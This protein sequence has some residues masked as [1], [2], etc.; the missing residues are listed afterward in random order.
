MRLTRKALSKFSCLNCFRTLFA[1]RVKEEY[2]EEEHEEAF[3]KDILSKVNHMTIADVE[4]IIVRHG[5]KL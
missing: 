1:Q 4:R 2:I 3:F 5:G